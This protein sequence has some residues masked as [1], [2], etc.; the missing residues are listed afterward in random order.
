MLSPTS[1][2]SLKG[3]LFR[4]PSAIEEKEYFRF[5]FSRTIPLNGETFTICDNISF[6]SFKVAPGYFNIIFNLMSFTDERQGFV[7]VRF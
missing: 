4:E 5:L 7:L 3:F 6:V 2:I 1:P